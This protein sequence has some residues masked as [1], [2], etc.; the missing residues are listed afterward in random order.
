MGNAVLVLGNAD[1]TL[2]ARLIM[3]D[4]GI[5]ICQCVRRVGVFPSSCMCVSEPECPLADIPESDL[6]WTKV[7]GVLDDVLVN[8][9][10][11]MYW[12]DDTVHH[13]HTMYADDDDDDDGDGDGDGDDDDDD[14]DLD[15]DLARHGFQM[16]SKCPGIS[17]SAS[18]YSGILGMW[19]VFGWR[20]S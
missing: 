9:V 20:E 3:L 15:L 6:G 1:T 8:S 19:V 17:P 2:G 4:C 7:H 13:C 12:Q 14:D 18:I 10:S 5:D 16:P 11:Y